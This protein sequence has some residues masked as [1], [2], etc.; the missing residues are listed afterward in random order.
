MDKLTG[1]AVFAKVAEKQNFTAAARDLGVSKSAVSK[2]VQRLEDRLGVRLLNRTTRR[3]HLTE[4]GQ[5]F[6]ERARRVVEEAEEAEFAVTR[7]HAE[8]RGTLRINAPMTFGLRHLA[9]LIPQF[10]K[11]Y[12]DLGIDIAF[13]DRQVDLIEE[14]FD[15]GIRIADLTD[16][17][18]I[19]RK[20]APCRMSVVATPEFWDRNGRP[21]HPNQLADYE[22]LMYQHLR[23][24]R[25]WR[26]DG[27]NGLISVPVHGRLRGDNGEAL[28]EM[29]KAGLGAYLCPTFMSGEL[30]A[31]GTLEAVLDDFI[32]TNV[33]VYAIWPHNRH[34]SAKVRT[35]VDFLIDQY[36][37]KPYWDCAVLG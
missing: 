23:T 10:I 3:L 36:G 18:L 24:R 12:P 35:F 6:Y 22:C 32:R 28:L 29:A 26:F 1:M 21:S 17:S 9:P 27:P 2:Q 19:A 25:E 20:L 8:P 4:S 7:L 13:N 33:S 15:V 16:S 14:G 30:I 31:S 34:L 11:Q 5:A 37:H